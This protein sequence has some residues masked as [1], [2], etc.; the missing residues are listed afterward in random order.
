MTGSDV[1]KKTNK[2]FS[3]DIP[4]MSLTRREFI[5]R[6]GS[7]TMFGMLVSSAGIMGQQA[8]AEE[9]ASGPRK[10][11]VGS[12]SFV[13]TQ[14]AKRDKK[15]FDVGEV[16]S[17]LGDCGYDYLETGFD[18]VHPDSIAKLADQMKS[19]GLKPVS[20]Y[21]GPRLH[22]ADKARE[23][24]NQ[25]LTAMK[26][27]RECG[28]QAISCNVAPIGHEKT[29]EELKNQVAAL[30]DLGQGMKEIGLKLGIHHHLPEMNNNARE[31][32][33]NFRN[34][35]PDLVGFCYDVHWVWKG[36]VQPADALREYGERV[37]TWHIRQSRDGIW[38]ED[39]D[40]GDID[41]TA[42]AKYVQEH[43][44]SRLL[45]V[46]LAIEGKTQITRSAVENH[47]RSREFIRKVFGV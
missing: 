40:T 35:P 1:M 17:A 23:T 30:K 38:W 31:F 7:A 43:N 42:I 36:G 2:Q 29:E 13:W 14:Y 6:T 22:E 37:V 18:Y 16:M 39:L 45:T 41:Y 44:L 5:S 9:K 27:C 32:H 3:A 26:V 12:N 47:R 4:S 19:K 15:Q 25:L 46:E 11:M 28:F 20:L 24:V 8:N 21:V 33:Y 10:E 34:T